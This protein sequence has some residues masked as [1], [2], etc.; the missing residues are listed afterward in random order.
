[1]DTSSNNKPLLSII[2]PA[3]N[4]EENIAL[5]IQNCLDS[6]DA[7]NIPGEV[8]V[9][10]DGSTDQTENIIRGWMSKDSRVHRVKHEKPH[11]IGASFWE[12]VDNAKGEVTVMLPG[13]NEND[14]VE[15]LRYIKLIEHVDIIIPFVYNKQ[16]RSIFRNA[17]SFL[18]RFII[19]TTFAV[20]FNYTNGTILYRT[21]LLKELENRSS[22]FFF[23]TDILIRAV[24]RGYLFAEVPY[25]LSLRDSGNS[26]AVTF[27]SFLNV[28]KGYLKLLKDYYSIKKGKFSGKT[29]DFATD[30]LTAKRYNQ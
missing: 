15:I 14:P 28:V 8:I 13:D 6:L 16:V 30:S 2:M 22:G 12:G 3:L 25:K 17:L 10:N 20:N 5:A 1:M 26:T 27:P 11:G 21:S 29:P 24:K 18:Y 7:Y 9:V 23:Q 19:N 4:E